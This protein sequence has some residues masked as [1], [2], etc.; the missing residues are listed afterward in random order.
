MRVVVCGGGVIGLST[1]MMLAADGHDVLVLE[2]DPQPPTSAGDAWASWERKGVPQF[3]QPHNL[4]PRL[5]R[6]LDDHLPEVSERLAAAGCNLRNALS[7]A[8]PSVGLVL[9]SDEERFSF[10][11]GR[12]PVAEACFAGAAAETSGVEVR[13]GVRVTGYLFEGSRVVGVE[14]G[15]EQLRADLVIDA[16]GR[17]SPT[18]DWLVARGITPHLESQDRGYAY[19][20][21]YFRGPELPEQRGP[22]VMPL[23]SFSLLTLQGDNDTWSVTLFATSGDRLLKGVRD[24]EAFDRVV[25]ACP[26]QAHWLAGE[27]ISDVVPMAGVLD[28]YRRFVDGDRPLVTGLLAVG[29]AWACT[30]PS[31]GRGLSVGMVHA[32]VLCDALRKH[33][34]DLAALQLGF[35]AATEV[36]VTPFFRAQAT[37]DEARIAE[38]E[39]LRDGRPVP[40]VDRTLGRLRA[41]AM[42]D[43]EVFRAM[44]ELMTCM[45]LPAEILARPRVRE[46]LAAVGDV[47]PGPVPA[48]DRAQLAALIG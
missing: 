45:D 15:G 12:R 39:A 36:N 44:V 33:G 46:A 37:A 22:A 48:P 6:V 17:S 24:P 31:A 5:Q 21:R 7:A 9:P 10:L 11:T 27:P 34:D 2:H 41:A 26:M 13:R 29:D 4:F 20:T 25:G 47:T 38:M 35:D 8:P 23:G 1:A 19:Y 18:V 32:E 42:T 40:D 3:R 14:A 16:M 43:A 30:N 28:R